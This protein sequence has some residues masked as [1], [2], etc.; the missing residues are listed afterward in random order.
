VNGLSSVIVAP[1]QSV[2]I[3]VN[4]TAGN[5][6]NE[7]NYTQYKIGGLSAICVNTNDHDSGANNESFS[8]NA[9]A[10]PGV[11]NLDITLY[12]GSNCSSNSSSTFTLA[13]AITVSIPDTTAPVIAFHADENAEATSASGAV[14]TYTSPNAT[15]NVDATAP[16]A[17][18]PASGTTFA[19]GTTTV[20]CNKTDAAGNTATPTT[21]NVI[22]SDTTAPVITL[23]GSNPQ[24]V[25]VGNAYS[26]LGATVVDNYDTGLSAVVDSSAVNTASV[27][28]YSV[29]YNVTDS[30]SNVAT[31]KTRTVNVV[32]QEA[33]VV[34][35]VGA[36]P[37]IIEVHSTYSELGA[38]V[39]DNYDTGLSAVVD[40]S[41]VNTDVVGSY[42]V[43]YNATDSSENTAT[44]ATRT[45]NVVD[46]TKPVITL[47]GD[48]TINIKKGGS[49]TDAGATA[50][51]NY[52][53]S[54]TV[55]TTN[56][57]NTAIP[58]TYT[59]SYNV[60]D[61]N[62]NN[63]DQVTR[64][65]IVRPLGLDA[66]L[67]SLVP[68]AGTLSP[69]FDPETLIYTVV[70]PFGTTTIPTVS[71]TT[72]DEFATKEITQPLSVTGTA[73]VAVTSEDTDEEMVVHKT[74]TVN[75]SVSPN[76]DV[77]P[78]IEGLQTEAPQGKRLVDG[79][80]VNAGRGGGGI[81]GGGQVLGAST[82][83]Q[84][85][86]ASTSC[87]I[88]LSDY[89]KKGS[90][91]NKDAVKKLQ[92][93]LNDY[94]KLTPP[95]PVNGIFG[96]QTFKAVV[97]FQEQESEYVLKPWGGKKGTGYVYKTTT[98]RINNLKCPDLKL[99][100]PEVN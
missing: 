36:N 21:F 47:T 32:D 75:F 65:V 99:P 39:V 1:S 3:L 59:V 37:Q 38:T 93:F 50:T 41:A 100:I 70:L 11:Y 66:T 63:A 78:N 17:C 64:T 34:T 30:H 43:K 85:L 42:T 71:A 33:P 86:G 53:S 25:L 26:E 2:T 94:L 19:L 56:P 72:T 67:S 29:T 77:C 14:V 31:T 62:G 27:G 5:G 69:V 90:K 16:A 46:T 24:T 97:K 68:S 6:N 13:N 88:Y 73:T 95:I 60:T 58:S 28:S 87:G 98:T 4:A 40:S 61:A 84:V 54:V 20:T 49:Y 9:P 82:T 80:C 35:V 18:T 10:T 7:W 55:N 8:A 45:V 23:N 92:E 89:I 15:D 12:K 51:D 83:G 96:P 57:V 76:L 81:I 44:E 48:A 91:N 79:Q 22:V 74:Y 52:D